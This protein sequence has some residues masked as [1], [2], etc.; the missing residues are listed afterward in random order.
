METPPS[1]GRLERT[2]KRARRLRPRGIHARRLRRAK[3]KEEEWKRGLPVGCFP[4]DRA[5]STA[6]G[7]EFESSSR[8]REQRAAPVSR[9]IEVSRHPD[10]ACTSGN[11]SQQ[12]PH[13]GVFQQPLKAALRGVSALSSPDR[14]RSPARNPAAA[15]ETDRGR[16]A[17]AL[18]KVIDNPPGRV[19]ATPLRRKSRNV[20]PPLSSLAERQPTRERNH[21]PLEGLAS[22]GE[23]QTARRGRSPKSRRWGV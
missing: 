15:G 5:N 4:R 9:F 8:E 23:S 16:S 3:E 14:T 6:P 1:S 19:M 10:S 12:F 2:G 22:R 20:N 7:Y 18:E 21:S 13:S 17:P 11:V